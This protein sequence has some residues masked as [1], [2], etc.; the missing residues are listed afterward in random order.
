MARGFDAER[1]FNFEQLDFINPFNLNLALTIP[2]GQRYPVSPQLSYGLTLVYNSLVFDLDEIPVP[3]GSITVPVVSKI[4]NAGA[5]WVL[6]LGQLFPPSLEAPNGRLEDWLWVAPDGSKHYLY[7]ELHPGF[8]DG[9][10]DT[11]YT[12]SS[13][14]IRMRR[15]G[16][17]IVELDFPEG[18]TRRFA[19]DASV[20][21]WRL[22]EIRDPAVD[23]VTITYVDGPT[24]RT[25]SVSDTHGREHVVS[26]VAASQLGADAASASSSRASISRRSAV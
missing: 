2:I 19:Y 15:L 21:E 17:D 7:G 23:S 5:G 6:S 1:M 14:Y 10:N 3:P 25:W 22:V 13:T 16:T 8:D 11:R 9:S 4:M 18:T 20:E 12:R 24:N 26:L